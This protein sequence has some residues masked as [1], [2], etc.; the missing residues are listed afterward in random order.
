MNLSKAL[1]TLD[2]LFETFNRKYFDTKLSKH[3]IVI[4]ST[5]KKPY[6]GW[7]TPAKVWKQNDKEYNEINISAEYLNRDLYGICSTLLHEMCH[8]MNNQLEIKDTSNG[9]K[10]H[11]KKFK[12]M[13]E[14]IGLEIKHDNRIGWSITQLSD[15]QKTYVDEL[16]IDSSVF[17]IFR[18]KFIK[19]KIENKYKLFNYECDCGQRIKS[20]NDVDELEI[21]C[22]LCNTHFNQVEVKRGRRTKNE[23]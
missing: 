22:S 8:A 23:N 11:N 19:P 10:Y 2:N 14:S 18:Q 15:E 4:D 21:V 16:K 17:N 1:E 9:N 5:G 12:Y 20:L 6:Y 7:F 13:A 3:V